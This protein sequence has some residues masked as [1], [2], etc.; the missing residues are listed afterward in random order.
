MSKKAFAAVSFGT[1]YKDALVS[2][3]NVENR[4]KAVLPEHDFYR[5]F[6][7]GTVREKL[8]KD[9]GAHI[10]SLEELLE[11]LYEKGYEEVACQSL[12]IV[13]GKQ[14]EELVLKLIGYGRRFRKFIIGRPLLYEPSDCLKL[15]GVIADILPELQE[16]EAFVYMGHGSGHISNALYALTENCLRQ[17]SKERVYVGVMEGVPGIEYIIGRLKKHSIKKT[18]LAPM[19]LSAGWHARKDLAGDNEESWKSRLEAEGIQVRVMLKGLGDIPGVA[20]IFA[21]RQEAEA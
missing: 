2:I 18:W 19:L 13:P 1:A 7:S 21:G 8:E 6:T 16:D 20:E 3:G 9:T 4:L 14:Y 12:H 10:L 11:S 15:A 17:L 5:V